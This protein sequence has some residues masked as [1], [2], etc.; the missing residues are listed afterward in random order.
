M[1]RRPHPFFQPACTALAS[2]HG[3]SAKQTVTGPAEPQN[4]KTRRDQVP[5][6][7]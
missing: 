7:V 3:R 6:R 1:Q 5:R 4:E 2:A